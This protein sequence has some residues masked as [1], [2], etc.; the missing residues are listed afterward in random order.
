MKE[1]V[2]LH[3]GGTFAMETHKNGRLGSGVSVVEYIKTHIIP[4]YQDLKIDQI[5]LFNIDSSLFT[6]EHWI[7][8]AEKIRDIYDDY[9][10]FIII[11]GT[12]TLSYSAAALSFMLKNLSKPVIFTGSQL[13]YFEK[14]SD[15]FSNLSASLEVALHGNLNEVAVVFNNSAYRGNRVKKKDVFDFDA[16]YSPNFEILIKMG[17]GLEEHGSLFLPKSDKKLELDIRLCRDILIIPFFPGLDF[18]FYN[19]VLSHNNLRGILIE[20][21][22]NGNIPSDNSGLDELFSNGSEKKIPI[23]VCS[24][25]PVGSVNLAIYEA[26][27]K[28]SFYGLI[29]AEDM[30]LET[31]LV[32][33]MIALG[34]YKTL[35]DIKNFMIKN[36]AGEKHFN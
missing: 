29:S 11:H 30:T 17:I 24:Q 33:L 25:A 4:S 18:N 15:A 8:L 22:G 7:L 5:Q 14:R 2:I 35:E 26:A 21:Y 20:A 34:R 16:F 28:A 1:M 10:G 9:D 6:P 27:E 36:I 3:T 19:P 32:K 23:V 31:T 12:D 13:P